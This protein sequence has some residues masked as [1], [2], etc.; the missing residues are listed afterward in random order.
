MIAQICTDCPDSA[1]LKRLIDGSLSTG[2]QESI[3]A[4]LDCCENCQQSIEQIAA[5]GSGL[6]DCAK[7]CGKIRPD[8][9]SAYWPAVK[10][11]ER[12][13][14]HSTASTSAPVTPSP[15]QMA[16][17]RTEGSDGKAE[18][19][20]FDFL[21]PAEEPGT[22]GKL[23]RFHVVSSI[24]QGGMGMV[25]R[26]MDVCLQRQVAL[27]VLDP[28]LA[29]NDLA[30]NRFIREARAAAS[31]THENVVAVHHVE[32]HRDE[33]PFL[34]MRLVEGESLQDLLDKRGGPLAI[35]DV[36]DIGRQVAAGLAA[37]HEKTLIHRDIKPANILIEKGTGKVLLTDFGLA[38]AMEDVKLT[39]SGFVAGTP[40]YMSP[41]Q[42]RGE[43]LDNRSDLFS[44]GSLLYAMCTGNPPFQGSSAFVVLR[45]VTEGRHRPV[46]EINP[47]VPDDLAAIIDHLLAKKPENRI[48]S[49]A[50]VA[51]LLGQLSTRLPVEKFASTPVKRPTRSFP[52]LQLGG[53][54]RYVAWAGLVV[55]GLNA[56]VF[57]S[58]LTRLTHWTVL[59]QRSH[60]GPKP[61]L[62]L[63]AGTG[64]IWSVAYSPNGETVAMAVDDGS[65][66]LWNAHTGQLQSRISAHKRPIWCVA[67]NHDGTML[68][69][70]SDD[71]N[72]RL[73]DTASNLEIDTIKHN[74]SVRSVAFSTDGKRIVTG[75]R[76]GEVRVY[77]VKSGKQVITTAGHTDGVVM[78]VAFS[79]DGKLIAS[80]SGDQT[81]K[82]WD[83]S[84][85][86]GKEVVTLNGHTG[87][88]YSVAF[89][90]TKRVV[91]SG[92]WDRT[93]RVWNIDSGK[94]TGKLE[95][96][97][98]DIWSVSFCPSEARLISGSEDQTAKVWDVATGKELY[99]IKG[100]VGTIYSIAIG[101]SCGTIATAGRDGT[102]KLWQVQ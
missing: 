22:L 28:Q 25:L 94:E 51:D 62:V 33:I 45:A 91:A 59:G 46:Q 4:H 50:E 67:Y 29:K 16:V 47:N 84:T 23:G 11:L 72:V 55:I 83:V 18:K 82:I 92:S 77:D 13:I 70:A 49:A 65:V 101:K 88:V 38:R 85:D 8:G 95:G 17:T 24:G 37:A 6:L 93:I 86:D 64:P 96:H 53:W 56:L 68:A 34:V 80:A 102:V 52:R 71:G 7:G 19:P 40:L 44:L 35:R 58:E 69:T 97:R 42:A 98:E 3:T 79:P 39:Q 26:A 1:D 41:E 61:R 32:H 66:R 27:K 14:F 63:D 36:V 73:W 2:E 5:G 100:H 99:T 30:R 20:A 15:S 12:E 78:A 57:V 90:P 43:T 54:R 31:I 60:D 74:S 81:V 75:T 76:G 48:Q 89:H 21:D 87:G 9:T 10:Q